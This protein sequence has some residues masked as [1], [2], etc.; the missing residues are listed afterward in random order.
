[1]EHENV[2]KF[3]KRENLEKNLTLSF[4]DTTLQA[5]GLKLR[6][7]RAHIIPSTSLTNT[8]FKQL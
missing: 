8:S 5:P 4:T 2:M 6:H 3:R 1:M 7:G